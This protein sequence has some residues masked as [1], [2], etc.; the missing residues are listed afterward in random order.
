MEKW[1]LRAFVKF[2][3]EQVLALSH[4]EGSP[5]AGEESLWITSS[6]EGEF[7]EIKRAA[8]FSCRGAKPS[9][10][11]LQGPSELAVRLAM[12]S[13]SLEHPQDFTLQISHHSNCDAWDIGGNPE[14]IG[15]FRTDFNQVIP[16]NT[17]IRLTH[18][19]SRPRPTIFNG[20]QELWGEVGEGTLFLEFTVCGQDMAVPNSI[21]L[22]RTVWDLPTSIEVES[23]ATL[24]ITQ[25][26]EV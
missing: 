18:R 6:G 9:P 5:Y 10:D 20:S 13:V 3:E 16:L 23:L 2:V 24:F 12:C 19:G 26:M 21:P 17:I 8:L 15:E 22:C 11:A 1:Q 14:D 4:G 25:N 7:L